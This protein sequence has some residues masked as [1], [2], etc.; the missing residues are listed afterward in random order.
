[1]KI[2]LFTKIFLSTLF[3][4][5]TLSLFLSFFYLNQQNKT[6][7]DLLISQKLELVNFLERFSEKENHFYYILEK[8]EN[9]VGFFWIY[10]SEG[11]ITVSSDQD[12]IDKTPPFSEKELKRVNYNNRNYLLSSASISLSQEDLFFVFGVEEVKKSPNLIFLFL[13]SLFFG[14]IFALFLNKYLVKTIKVKPKTEAKPKKEEQKAKEEDLKISDQF[15]SEKIKEET[16]KL[17]KTIT[18]LEN[19]IEDQKEKIEIK[20][21]ELEKFQKLTEGREKKIVELKQK[22]KELEDKL[23]TKS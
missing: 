23:K 6:T 22:I 16:D 2:N 20:K 5:L 18:D 3:L 19:K 17:D 14:F 21:E 1:M 10:N 11:L 9:E 7:E 8:L 13:S 12:L 15:I 4:I